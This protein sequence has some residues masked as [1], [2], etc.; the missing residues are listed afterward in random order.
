MKKLSVLEMR[1]AIEMIH[2]C[3]ATK[4][5]ETTTVLNAG[6]NPI[7]VLLFEVR[8]H[9]A[10]TRC[11]VWERTSSTNATAARAVLCTDAIGTAAQALG[12]DHAAA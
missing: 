8:G 10:A 11:F 7:D 3:F 1:L 12:F 5:V 6:P 4:L 2:G 9:P